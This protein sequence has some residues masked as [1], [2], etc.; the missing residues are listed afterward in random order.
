MTLNAQEKSKY[1]AL[2][3]EFRKELITMLHKA[4]SG[5]AG[6]SLSETEI[7]TSIYFIEGKFDPATPKKNDSFVLCKGH[8]APMLY[9]VLAEKGYFPKSDLQHLRQIGSHLQGHPCS[10]HTPGVEVSTGP[11]GMG[12]PVALGMALGDKMDGKTE[13]YVY[14]LL[15]DGEIN[16]G[17]VWETAMN[18]AKN[19]AVNLISIVDLNGVQLD[20]TTDQVMPMGDVAAKFRSFGYDVL[21]C[22]GHDLCSICNAIEAAKAN[23]NRP[24]MILAHTI[25]GKGISFMEGKNT[26][27]GKM[28]DDASYAAAM[29]ELEE[30]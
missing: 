8:A 7:L 18:I 27:H 1:D 21:E 2:C 15:G 13:R 16:E 17:V 26:W 24:S 23:K 28:I 20:G 25:K 10:K 14:A 19:N 29:K 22:D 12:Y 11:L 9:E 4:G 5:H 3:K 6:G 30:N